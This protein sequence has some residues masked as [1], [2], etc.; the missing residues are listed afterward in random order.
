MFTALTL[1]AYANAVNISDECGLRTMHGW[2]REHRC[3][4]M[5]RVPSG[6]SDR[7]YHHGDLANALTA[8]ATE[9]ARR[10]GPEAVVLREAARQVGVSATA[11]YRHFT[12]HTDL[13]DA[14]KDQAL[15]SLAA[16]MEVELAA[17]E[18]LSD[19]AADGLRRL[20]ALGSAYVGFALA[21]PGLFRTS[22]CRV[23]PARSM[24][25][26][27]GARAYVLLAEVL[28]DLVTHGVLAP[29]RRPYAEVVMW[30]TVHGLA[31][32]LLDGPLRI[33]PEAERN[34]AVERTM[35]FCRDAICASAPATASVTRV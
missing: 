16:A 19:P 20:R 15:A 4:K 6:K 34:Q 25:G 30:A 9:L 8:A 5:R 7:S 26:V 17:T 2:D 31:M 33:L 29:S 24:S 3:G 10:G 23:D 12:A 11:A 28:D 18:A 35:E 14:V 27:A 1:A 32:L 13:I 21:E 22:C